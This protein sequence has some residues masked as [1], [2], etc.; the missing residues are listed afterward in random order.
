LGSA[1][2]AEL[3]LE[4]ATERRLRAVADLKRNLRQDVTPSRKGL[5]SHVHANPVVGFLGYGPTTASP[6]SELCGVFRNSFSGAAL[7][8]AA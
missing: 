8:V 7:L 1:E 6:A 2:R 3:A 4:R 5:H